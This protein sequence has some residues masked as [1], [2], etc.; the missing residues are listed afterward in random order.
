LGFYDRAP[1]QAPETA[2]PLPPKRDDALT[3]AVLGYGHGMASSLAALAGAY[4]VFAND[5]ARAPLTL[6]ARE[7]GDVINYTPVFS[8]ETAHVV[9]GMMRQVVT[10]GT[11]KRAEVPGLEIAGKTGSAEKP[12]EGV[13]EPD[14]LFSSFAAVF[15]ASNPKYVIVLALDQPQRTAESGGLATGGAVAAPS[16]G[17]IAARLAALPA[18]EAT[19]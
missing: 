7:Q 6:V 17:A 15:P 13:Y 10:T 2:R 8:K 11:G 5:G 3:N 18:I 12:H 19:R 4:T 9:L 16:V 14:V 1:I